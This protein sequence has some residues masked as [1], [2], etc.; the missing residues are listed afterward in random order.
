MSSSG[1]AGHE[2]ALFLFFLRKLH[3]VSTVA[4]PTY[5]PTNS[6]GSFPFLFILSKTYYCRL[7]DDIHSDYCEVISHCSFDLH[8]SNNLQC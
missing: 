8:F 3:T 4:A 7:F 6:V 1:I 2:A 5:I